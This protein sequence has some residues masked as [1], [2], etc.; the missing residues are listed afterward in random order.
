[1][2]KEHLIPKTDKGIQTRNKLFRA[3]EYTFGKKGYHQGSV[4]EITQLA[5]VSLGTFYT[6]FESKYH[7]FESLLWDMLGELTRLI[8]QRTA[9]I[10]NRIEKEREGFRALLYF[11]KER[12][13]WYNLFPQAEFVDKDLH[14]KIFEEFAQIYIKRIEESIEK[15]QIRKLNSEMLVY[16]L[17]GIVNYIGLKWIIW[18]KKDITDDML[19]EIMDFITYGIAKE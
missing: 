14:R 4:T 15:G 18:D 16:S 12:P 13:Y 10:E 8:R 3:A 6:Y 7:I 11:L 2:L 17:M 1:M 19:D 5:E 9:G